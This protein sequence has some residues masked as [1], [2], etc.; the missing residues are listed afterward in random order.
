M[1]FESLAQTRSQRILKPSTPPPK[2]VS[3]FMEKTPR[4][5]Q[6]AVT[7]SLESR[8]KLDP[9]ESSSRAPY[10]SL[11]AMFYY[12]YSGYL[13][14]RETARRRLPP[15][16][17]RSSTP[18]DTLCVRAVYN[19]LHNQASHTR[20]TRRSAR[21]TLQ[22]AP[23]WTSASETSRA[24]AGSSSTRISSSRSA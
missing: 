23:Q 24:S 19:Q 17:S 4:T 18:E 2:Y 12:H 15:K 21:S 11:R 10:P 1:V 9:R 6:G 5:G 20:K 3:N 14:S 22:K 13:I 8:L 7:R 16:I